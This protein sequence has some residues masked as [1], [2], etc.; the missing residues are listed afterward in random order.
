MGSF[1][2]TAQVEALGN[3]RFDWRETGLLRLNTGSAHRAQRRYVYEVD[4]MKSAIT[5]FYADGQSA[6]EVLH[7]FVFTPGFNPSKARHIHHCARD[8]Y[9]ANLFLAGAS[10]FQL[11]YQVGGPNK[12]Y[13]MASCYRKLDC[14]AR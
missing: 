4:E 7:H 6:G 3:G 9:V 14:P 12:T 2:G 11:S 13:V 10:R 8:T 1:S 5:L